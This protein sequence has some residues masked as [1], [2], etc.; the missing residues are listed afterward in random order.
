MA[1]YADAGR[2]RHDQLLANAKIE[3]CLRY[4]FSVW[5]QY[6]GWKT[7]LIDRVGIVLS[8]KAEGAAMRVDLAAFALLSFEKIA[9]VELDARFGGHDAQPTT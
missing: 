9:G 1:K 5:F 3:Y 2:V 4:E 7:W 6:S 8:L